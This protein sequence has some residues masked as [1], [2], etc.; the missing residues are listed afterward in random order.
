MHL[1][2]L[3]NIDLQVVLIY[4]VGQ[5]AT[6]CGEPQTLFLNLVRFP[7]FQKIPERWRQPAFVKI[8]INNGQTNKFTHSIESLARKK[9]TVHCH[10]CDIQNEDRK[11]KRIHDMIFAGHGENPS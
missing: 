4:Q 2:C 8:E 10:K 7:A 11:I 6:I 3:M 1:P 5:S 9:V